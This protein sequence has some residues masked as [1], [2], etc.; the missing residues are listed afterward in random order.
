M[1]TA[2][3]SCSLLSFHWFERNYRTH[4]IVLQG[5]TEETPETV[6][7]ESSFEEKLN[8]AVYDIQRAGEMA[9]RLE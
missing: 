9:Q 8:K 4:S 7:G 5:A 3:L 2:L 6:R 1:W